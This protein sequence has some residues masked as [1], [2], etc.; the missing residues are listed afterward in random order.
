MLLQDVPVVLFY[1][2]IAFLYPHGTL[3]LHPRGPHELLW[4]TAQ[5]RELCCLTGDKKVDRDSDRDILIT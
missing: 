5:H 3:M 4:T 2:T 1:L